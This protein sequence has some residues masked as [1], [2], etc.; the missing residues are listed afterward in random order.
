MPKLVKQSPYSFYKS[1][2]MRRHYGFARFAKPSHGHAPIGRPITRANLNPQPSPVVGEFGAHLF[3]F[4]WPAFEV[5]F[6]KTCRGILLSTSLAIE[7][8]SPFCQ[9]NV[10]F[11]SHLFYLFH[12]CLAKKY[13]QLK[14][15]I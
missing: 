11:L 8:D 6:W 4:K 1:P 5:I 13:L 15:K 2:Y 12:Y 3:S 10:I 14:Y 7:Y 9:R